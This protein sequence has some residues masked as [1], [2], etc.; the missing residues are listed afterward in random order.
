MRKIAAPLHMVVPWSSLFAAGW[1]ALAAAEPSQAELDGARWSKLRP[2]PA[3]APG[4]HLLDRHVELKKVPG[5][6]E[7][8]ARWRVS[9]ERPGWYANVLLVAPEV[10][11]HAV[12]IGGKPARTWTSSAG[13]MV[14]ERIEKN[15]QLELE[16][17]IP[18]SVDAGLQ[19]GLLAAPRGEVAIESADTPLRVVDLEDR[20]VLRRDNNFITGT[21]QLRIEP[22]R[23]DATGSNATLAV[24][25]VG[26]GLTVGDGA[27]SGRAHARWEVRR[28]TLNTVSLQLEGVGSDLQVE[29]ANVADWTRNGDSVEVQLRQPA[30]SRVDVDLSWTAAVS[31]AAESSLAVPR[32]SPQGVFRTES[33]LQLARDG[34][35]DVIPQMS[36]WTNI[37]AAQLP[38][39]SRG[40][41]QGTPTAAFKKPGADDAGTLDLVRYVT[42]PTPPMVIDVADIR[43]ASSREGRFVMR[44]RYEVSN[45]RAAHLVFRPPPGAQLTGVTVSGRPVRAAKVGDAYRIPLPRSVE[46][47]EGLS[48]VPV[49]VGLRG[50]DSRWK[51]RARGDIALPT[52][53]APV[54]VL[55]ASHVLP[56]GYRSR[57]DPGEGTVVEAFSR[58]EHVAYGLDDDQRAS[59][60]DQL[61]ADAVDAWNSN[62]FKA[63]KGKLE[64]IDDL[65]GDKQSTQGLE[66][67][68]DLVLEPTIESPDS[69]TIVPE[70]AATSA[71]KRPAPVSKT[72]RRIKAQVRARADKK[73]R[74]YRDR[75]KKA[76]NLQEEGRYDE[77]EQE[78]EKA[79]EDAKD[80]D[81]LEDEE[82]Q[83]YAFEADEIESE[84]KNTRKQKASRKA[85][86]KAEYDMLS[87]GYHLFAGADEPPERP[88]E[89]LPD[90]VVPIVV[91]VAGQTVKHEFPL[92][93][94]G[95]A[96]RIEF[97]AR[98]PFER[99]RRR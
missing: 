78:Y 84:L 15:T 49:V 25:H 85:L 69:S 42:V 21:G 45:E 61:Y 83:S 72:A 7:V 54:A 82:S 91:P 20:P 89:V 87:G 60:A 32:I 16:A 33:A 98:H 52:V 64:Q 63:A 94:P 95:A 93:E 99:R 10:H 18:G 44:A 65:G 8:R 12:R 41:V 48:L 28:G 31:K 3:L 6:V 81:R 71:P 56:P 30:D 90:P 19:L 79:L 77:A 24:A 53:D 26:I 96:R 4:P 40:L 11:L 59:Q 67:N 34:E 38:A 62:E 57:L 29:G 58:G 22:H 43:V 13:V 27:V 70:G 14:V 50:E 97:D 5:G 17:F 86:E 23:P 1:L 35:V 88:P 55:R 75:K 76:K 2:E 47:L 51:R 73:R 68:V 46:T 37:A 92:L 9:T 36:A 74:R 66:S 80:L 39:W